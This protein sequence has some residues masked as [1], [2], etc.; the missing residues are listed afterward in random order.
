MPREAL[1]QACVTL[2]G[3]VRQALL[4]VSVAAAPAPAPGQTATTLTPAVV[5]GAPEI[6]LQDVMDKETF[7]QA[8]AALDPIAFEHRRDE[9][10]HMLGM[11]VAILDREVAKR[12]PHPHDHGARLQGRPITVPQTECWE[13]PVDG[14][15]LVQGIVDLLKKYVVAA[16]W[17]FLTVALWIV[18]T[19]LLEDVNVTPRLRITSPKEECGKS[20]LASL[21]RYLSFKAVGTGHTTPAALFR[22]LAL[23]IATTAV[24]DEGDNLNWRDENLVAV[25]NAGWIKSQATVWRTVGDQLEPREFVIWAALV[26]ASIGRVKGTVESRGITIPMQRLKQTDQI[27]DFY[28]AEQ[29]NLIQPVADNL[30]R[31]ALRWTQ[32]HR[33]T[34]K[35]HKPQLPK[36]LR[37]RKANNWRSLL[38]IADI[39]GAPWA[40]NAREAVQQALTLTQE[41]EDLKTLLLR[42]LQR[43][44]AQAHKD[45]LASEDLI[46]ALHTLEDRPWAEYGEKRKPISKNQV[47]ALLS[48]FN[49]KPRPVRRGTA[50]FRGYLRQDCEDTFER[51]LAQEGEP[52][53]EKPEG[54][55]IDKQTAADAHHHETPEQSVTPLQSN[56]GAAFSACA[57]VTRSSGVTVEKSRNPAPAK[58]C[59]GVTDRAEVLWRHE[60]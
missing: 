29:D 60:I 16:E 46:A 2:T 33:D 59:N 12:R 17:V 49:I 58:E 44:F 40:T 26:I 48:H 8:L 14:S 32:D 31:R 30:R 43:L 36:G 34:I 19:F 57:T 47:A 53:D 51:Y 37:G 9:A 21:I 22:T 7:L 52:V 5:A 38:T 23:G 13:A 55:A 28:T 24:L 3:L 39:L 11:R 45:R 4:T 41:E 10:A 50:V 27:E 42:D 20:V 18:H 1:R 35:H 56:S 6:T 25:L 54:E 15:T